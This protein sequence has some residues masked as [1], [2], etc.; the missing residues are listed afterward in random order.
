MTKGN[1]SP[2]LGYDSKGNPIW[3]EHERFKCSKCR[4]WLPRQMYHGINK[5]ALECKDCRSKYRDISL[6]KP[7]KHKLAYTHVIR[8]DSV[9]YKYHTFFGSIPDDCDVIYTV[10]PGELLP[11]V[12]EQIPVFGDE[13]QWED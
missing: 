4:Q 2:P 11:G 10:N 6:Q 3:V 8:I 9:L 12:Y 1:G 13:I 5:R 7:V